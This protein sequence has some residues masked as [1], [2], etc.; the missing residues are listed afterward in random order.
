MVGA[1]NEGESYVPAEDCSD[2]EDDDSDKVC[3]F[4]KDC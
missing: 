2:E 3:R 4:H 1:D